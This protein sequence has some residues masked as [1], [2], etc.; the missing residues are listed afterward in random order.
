MDNFK[1]IKWLYLA[2]L[3]SLTGSQVLF[4]AVPL[5][6][7]K[8][9]HSA[10]YTGI[11]FSLEWIARII[12]FPLSG[13]AADRFGSKRVYVITDLIIGILCVISIS[14]M[15]LFHNVSL[16]VLVLLAVSAGF[17]SEQ[18]YVSAESLAPKLV[19]VKD[20]PKSQ[21]I[22]E[23]LELMALLFGPVL[24]GLFILYLDAEDLIWVAMVLY[25]CSALMMKKIQVESHR[26][27]IKITLIKN[28]LTGFH[29]IYKQNYLLSMV[30]LSMI[31]NMLFGLMTGSAPVMVLGV[32]AKP[33]SF[34]A[35]LNLTAGIF[36]V[37]LILSFNYLLRYVS[38]IHVGI[39]TFVI[40]C[41]SCILLGFSK[42]YYS[43][44]FLYAFF[45]GVNALFSIFFRS[46]RA[47]IIPSE[48]LGR[49]VGAIIFITFLLFPLSGILISF[50][51]KL[52]GLRILIMFFGVLCLLLGVPFLKRINQ[53]SGNNR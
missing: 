44:L 7:F 37:A 45:Y 43:Y 49:T 40:S 10:V 34:Y 33:D 16:I 11:A 39:A 19:S 20:Y 8:L 15:E 31:A 2:R 13:F 18:G 32:Y 26:V 35:M 51:Q 53:L 30:F 3:F 38:I 46:E 28:F 21:S 23:L 36:G 48:V 52:F 42:S 24:A 50:S 14:V 6:I 5:L 25:I 9:T 12:S 4:F 27:L 1:N 47:R 17:L 22:L 29:I 41:V